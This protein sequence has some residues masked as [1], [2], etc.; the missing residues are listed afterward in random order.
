[1]GGGKTGD[2]PFAA[3]R[4]SPTKDGG[5]NKSSPRLSAKN[6][7]TNRGDV[8]RRMTLLA[9]LGFLA[10]PARIPATGVAPDAPVRSVMEPAPLPLRA[11]GSGTLTRPIHERILGKQSMRLFSTS[12]E[13][14]RLKLEIDQNSRVCS[15]TGVRRGAGRFSVWRDATSE[16]G[17]PRERS[18]PGR[19]RVR[20]TW[21]S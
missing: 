6:P 12:P 9:S 18:R 14:K 2:L 17:C 15:K 7:F 5:G 11:V 4:A 16:R 13:L 21:S 10:W 19:P 8:F 3:T 1:M 20:I